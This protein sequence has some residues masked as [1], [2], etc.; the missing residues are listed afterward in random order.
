M[1]ALQAANC[2][3]ACAKVEGE[4][5]R[6]VC[7]QKHS[8]LQAPKLTVCPLAQPDKAVAYEALIG[9]WLALMH[10]RICLK[11][12]GTSDALRL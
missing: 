11:C 4:Y 2:E 5:Q 6:E 1:L 12:L 7:C 3:F 8:Q 9:P 10:N